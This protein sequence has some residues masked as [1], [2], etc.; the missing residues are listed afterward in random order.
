MS[1]FNGQVAVVTG[2]ADGLGK[3]IAKKL[4]SLGAVLVLVDIN[5]PLLNNTIIEFK[6]DGYDC[7]GI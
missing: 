5:Q 7:M 2:A 3:G 4:G 1:D 6:S